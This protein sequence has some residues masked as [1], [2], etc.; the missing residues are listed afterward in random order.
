MI[1]IRLAYSCNLPDPA[2]LVKKIQASL[3]ENKTTFKDS[4]EEKDDDGAKDR[5]D[6]VLYSF[7]WCFAELVFA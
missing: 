7:D 4:L 3:E 6:I 5:S 1:L 2:S